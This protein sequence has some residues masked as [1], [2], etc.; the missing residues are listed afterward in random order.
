[1]DTDS[2]FDRVAD[3]AAQT[4]ATSAQP[5]EPK[6][7]PWEKG[8]A[9]AQLQELLNAQ[10][11]RLLVDGDF[12]GKT[13]AAVRLF[14]HQHG[15]RVDGIVGAQTWAALKQTIQPG[16]RILDRGHIGA[17]VRE[18]QGLLQVNGY[19]IRRTGEFDQATQQAVIAFQRKHHLNANGR[20]DATTWA[21]LRG[22]PLSVQRRV[23][24]IREPN[25][26]W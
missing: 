20:V 10:G 1:M 26:W 7:Y 19:L 13:E 18:L 11:F 8:V 21:L 23:R 22:K 16:A 9:V 4:D 25:R 24:R 12:G 5:A 15:L 14:Q 2:G 17:D 3:H 6:L